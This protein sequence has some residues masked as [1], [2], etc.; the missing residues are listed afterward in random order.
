MLQIVQKAILH[1]NFD[2][3]VQ[4][5]FLSPC[6]CYQLIQDVGPFNLR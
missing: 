4:T 6:Y 3:D 5:Y 1:A 2:Y